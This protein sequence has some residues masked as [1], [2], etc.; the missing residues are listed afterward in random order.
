ME[1]TRKPISEIM[2]RTVCQVT[3]SFSA[4]QILELMSKK[5]VSSVLVVEDG[6]TL[7]IITE[8]D[9]VRNLHRSGSLRGLGCADLMQAPVV[10]VEAT[11]NCLDVYHLMGGRKIRHIAVTDAEGQLA[12]VVSEG[13][14]LRDFG[15]EYYTRFKDV[16]GAMN[17]DVCL[18]PESASVGEAVALMDQRRQSCVFAVDGARRPTGVLTERDIVRLCHQNE[19]PDSLPLGVVMSRPVRTATTDDLL[20]EAVQV[21]EGAGIRRL[22]VV[23][24][25]GSVRGVLTHHEVVTGLEGQYVAYLKD[26]VQRQETALQ[27]SHD[28][29]GEKRFLESILRSMA[30]TAV[31]VTDLH[32]RI[33]YGNAS[34]AANPRLRAFAA[35]GTDVREILTT[36]GWPECSLVLTPSALSAPATRNQRLEWTSGDGQCGFELQIA[37]LR[38]EGNQAAGYLL[39]LRELAAAMPNG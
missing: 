9:V 38:D 18:L 14:I 24:R 29:A 39:L 21:M 17:S 11:A 3:T 12:G 37:L 19:Q 26:R 27:D 10:T 7:G 22:A 5:S 15:I 32:C 33:V 25:E 13:D 35:N 34:V 16:G 31:V 23:D 1:T 20:H 2:T 30:G 28:V 36:L 4:S 6:L 8:R